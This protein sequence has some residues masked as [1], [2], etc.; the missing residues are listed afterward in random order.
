M[1]GPTKPTSFY[2]SCLLPPFV[3]G[4]NARNR[5]LLPVSS[6]TSKTK[7]FYLLSCHHVY[8]L[9]VLLTGHGPIDTKVTLS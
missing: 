1:Q 3:S 5:V 4:Q 7:G 2:S 9:P 8:F 6:H